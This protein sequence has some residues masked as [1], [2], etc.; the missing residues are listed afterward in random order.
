MRVVWSPQ[1]LSDRDAIWGFI[2]SDDIFAAIRVDTDFADAVEALAEYPELG[3]LGL[4]SG[5]RELF[6]VHNYR[7]VYEVNGQEVWIL[8]IA[9]TSRLW[10][11]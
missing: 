8:A 6:P 1:A 11:E 9:H 2:A 4:V 7:I 10:P 3:K 5:T